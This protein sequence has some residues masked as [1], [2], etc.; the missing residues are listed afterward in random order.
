MNDRKLL[1]FLLAA[2]GLLA[3]V[4]AATADDMRPSHRPTGATEPGGDGRLEERLRPVQDN[5][6][7]RALAKKLLSDPK[8]LNKL[9]DRNKDLLRQLL[10]DRNLQDLARDPEIAERLARELQENP[11]LTREQL[12]MLRKAPDQLAPRDLEK[13][14]RQAA[15][16]PRDFNL[17]PEQARRLEQLAKA[18]LD[19][20]L[21]D[22]SKADL[23]TILR[24]MRENPNLK[25][26]DLDAL[27]RA[28]PGLAPPQPMPGGPTDPPPVKVQPRPPVG[29]PVIP[30]PPPAVPDQPDPQPHGP[31]KPDAAANDALADAIV[32]AAD[33]LQDHDPDN[34][35]LGSAADWVRGLATDDGGERL[36]QAT[37]LLGSLGKLRDWVPTE[38]AKAAGS[39]LGD[40]NPP[41]LPEVNPP[42][43]SL[44]AVGGAPSFSLGDTE[45][46]ARLA[47]WGAVVAGL[48]F[49]AWKLAKMYREG[50]AG[51]PARWPVEPDAVVT[52][53]D[54]VRAFEYLALRLLGLDARHRHHLDLADRLGAP[55]QPD[56]D[57]PDRRRAAGH[58][59]HL[60]EL[61]RYAPE[62]EPL[63]E[64]EMAAARRD[65]SFLAGAAPA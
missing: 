46:L 45:G 6:L 24:Q 36:N 16:N 59:A 42:S 20:D 34:T 28:L 57:D 14:A 40:W 12:E 65:L 38:Q 25:R 1:A 27:K 2:C 11:N 56:A 21:P 19:G 61:A 50:A 60:Y 49:V 37:D 5:A 18:R 31:A 9:S 26:D 35:A 15:E 64:A 39:W 41:A 55:R 30:P 10:E 17:D 7:L 44:P 47:L 63:P 52:R 33:W 51:D 58:L 22:Q 8:Q 23:E 4:T 32:K 62:D 43:P 3:A 48:A 29:E 54:L 53:G 13:L